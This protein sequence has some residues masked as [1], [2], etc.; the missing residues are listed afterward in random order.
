VPYFAAALAREAAGWSAEELDLS[1]VEDFDGLVEEM[2]A[3]SED[4]TTLLLYVE[5]EDE[6]FALV[7]LDGDED[8]R[9]FLSDARA[10]DD[11]I[12]AILGEAAA[13]P[14]DPDDEPGEEDEPVADDEEE[15][16]DERLP[17]AGDPLGDAAI[18]ADLGLAGSALL[19]L[20]A[21]E[22]QL[23]SDVM[24]AACERIGCGE[25]FE[26]LRVA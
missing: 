22:G 12:G 15:D 24:S 4:A 11:P 20:C 13:P 25:A 7:R 17:V 19:E 2:R 1:E 8:P 5:Q 3:T 16:G 14:G 18:L 26:S 21:E 6:W 9:V 23:P 10:L